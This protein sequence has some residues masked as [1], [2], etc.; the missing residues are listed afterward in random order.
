MLSRPPTRAAGRC[1]MPV[2]TRFDVQQRG[3]RKLPQQPSHEPPARS[4]RFSPGMVA[5]PGLPAA[6]LAAAASLAEIEGAFLTHVECGG[7]PAPTYALFLLLSAFPV[8][9]LTQTALVTVPAFV[10][11]LATRRCPVVLLAVGVLA[12]LVL[13][14]VASAFF[15][16]SALPVYGG[17]CSAP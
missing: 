5:L 11:A 6:A 8:L 3:P 17:P 14:A 2:M 10:L 12:S 1:T 16:W 9:W 4:H 13:P 15:E 7:S